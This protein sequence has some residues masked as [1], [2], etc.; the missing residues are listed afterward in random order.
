MVYNRDSISGL[1][2]RRILSYY[3]SIGWRYQIYYTMA[4]I[5]QKKLPT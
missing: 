1:T 3:Y 4:L 2:K 5:G